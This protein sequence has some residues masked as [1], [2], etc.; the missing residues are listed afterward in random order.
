[1]PGHRGTWG[2][3]ELNDDLHHRC[4]K[5]DFPLGGEGRRGAERC[6]RRLID[7]ISRGKLLSAGNAS[8]TGETT[9]CTLTIMFFSHTQIEIKKKIFKRA[10]F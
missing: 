10:K 8:R 5:F 1:M 7:D 9:I 2:S 3:A 4:F 6:G